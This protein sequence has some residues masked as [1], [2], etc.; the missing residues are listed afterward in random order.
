[1]AVGESEV[2]NEEGES[3]GSKW[4]IENAPRIFKRDIENLKI[5]RRSGYSIIIL[6]VFTYTN[7]RH[8]PLSSLP[9]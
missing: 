5:F 3:N 1:M 2:R 9:P 6:R 7:L 8:L 4:C